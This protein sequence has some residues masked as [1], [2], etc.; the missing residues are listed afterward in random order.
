MDEEG[1]Y[2]DQVLKDLEELSSVKEKAEDEVLKKIGISR[3][4]YESSYEQ[5][6]GD[7]SEI[8]MNFVNK[9]FDAIFIHAIKN[10]AKKTEEEAIK[11]FKEVIESTLTIFDK[12]AV[13]GKFESVGLYF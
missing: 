8:D 10:S 11:L 6:I 9:S 2:I 4:C 12:E 3:L 7:E 5:H 13:L 1:Q